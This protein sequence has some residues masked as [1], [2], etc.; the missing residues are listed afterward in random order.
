KD[1]ANCVKEMRASFTSGS[2]LQEVY[3]N[4]VILAQNNGQ[5]WDELAQCIAW[6]RRNADVLADTHWVATLGIRRR[7]TAIFMAGPLG[8]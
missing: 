2:G 7:R 8:T 5:L 3:A 4:S 6:V 1:S